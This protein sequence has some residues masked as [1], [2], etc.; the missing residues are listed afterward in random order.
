M[1]VFRRIAVR[2]GDMTADEA[3]VDDPAIRRRTDHGLDLFRDLGST[4]FAMIRAEVQCRQPAGEEAWDQ[5]PDGVAVIEQ[6]VAVFR[7]QPL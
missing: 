6:G 3:A 1:Y 4:A 2:P 5:G 7:L